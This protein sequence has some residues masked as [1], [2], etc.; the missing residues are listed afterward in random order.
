VTIDT[1]HHI[2]PDFFWRET[3]DSHAPV[4]GLA[5]LQWSKEAMISFMD[6]AGI[7]V[8]VMSVSTPGVH[9]GDSEKA[10]SLARRCNEF[11]AE[12]VHARPDRFASF[13]CIPLPDIDSSLE[14]VSYAFDVLRLDGLVLFTNSNGIYLGDAALEPVFQELERRKAVV[15]VHPNPS[16][17][18]AAHSLGLP[19]N[20]LDFPTDTNRAVAQMHYTNRFARTPNVKYIFSHAGGSIP[21]LAARFAI[22]DE[23]GFIP[24]GDQRGSAAGMFRRMYWDTALAASDPV[25]RMLRDVAGVDRILFGTD[26]PYLRRD[27]AV[28]SKQQILQSSALNDSE[29]RAV[30]DGNASSLFPRLHSIIHERNGRQINR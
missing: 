9:L 15:F 23:M 17:D 8:A 2:L 29:R 25:L 27:L 14:E 30:L 21:Y 18:A 28:K 26:F 13:A 1:H 12:L 4:G 7:D 22:I 5:P 19:D 10:R 16:P 6:D 3:N 24:G 11:A 20:L